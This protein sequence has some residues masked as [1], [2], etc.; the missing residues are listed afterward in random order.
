MKQRID[1]PLSIEAIARRLGASRRQLE[2]HFHHSVGM[3]PM[4]AYK[5]MRLEYA[6]YLLKHSGRSVTE[7]ATET[8]FCDSSHFIRVFKERRGVTQIGRASCR[9]RVC[10]YV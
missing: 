2:R 7:V 8:G 4:L 5:I 1:R 10:Q 9:E 6:E 3:A